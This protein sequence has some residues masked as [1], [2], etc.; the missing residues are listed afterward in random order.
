[1]IEGRCNNLSLPTALFQ[2][3][4]GPTLSAAAPSGILQNELTG[5]RFPAVK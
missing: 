5:R 2:T 4:S 1:M 3:I